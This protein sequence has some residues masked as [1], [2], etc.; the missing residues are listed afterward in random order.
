MWKICQSAFLFDIQ[1]VEDD[2]TGPLEMSPRALGCQKKKVKDSKRNPALSQGKHL[3]EGSKYLAALHRRR[4]DRKES[5]RGNKK[6]SRDTALQISRY[7]QGCA[8][9]RYIDHDSTHNALTAFG[10]VTFSLLTAASDCFLTFCSRA[11]HG[12]LQRP[13]SRQ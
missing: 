7:P 3:Y 11:V 6:G 10:S 4:V 5:K 1:K 9:C 13:Q 12:Q 2:P 8:D